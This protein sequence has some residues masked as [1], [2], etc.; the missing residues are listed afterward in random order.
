MCRP[1]HKTPARPYRP[2]DSSP[3]TRRSGGEAPPA[4]R[5][6]RGA[7]LWV[8]EAHWPRLVVFDLDYTLWPLWVDTH[9]DPPLK[10]TQ[11][12]NQVVDRYVRCALTPRGGQPL[13]FYDPVPYVPRHSRQGDS[14]SASAEW[15]E[16]WRCVAHTCTYSRQAGSRGLDDHATGAAGAARVGPVPL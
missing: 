5:S 1:R 13:S 6:A 8:M 12:I 10:R 7:Y 3:T 4:E 9:V 2:V 15:R 16:D 14:V 11:H